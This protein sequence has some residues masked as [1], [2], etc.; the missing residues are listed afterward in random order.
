MISV[1][2]WGTNTLTQ[3]S[4]SNP[5]DCNAVETIRRC[6]RVRR[7]NGLILES[8][9]ENQTCSSKSS[10]Q[11]G[12]AANRRTSLCEQV[13]VSLWVDVRVDRLLNVFRKLGLVG[14]AITLEP[15]DLELRRWKSNPS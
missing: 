8:R 14:N 7:D 3:S 4:A 13:E 5:T 6:C 1:P 2:L 12:Q 11:L 10:G 15:T 9:F